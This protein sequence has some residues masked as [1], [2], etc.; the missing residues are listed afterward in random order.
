[1]KKITL[2]ICLITISL[3]AQVV[4]IPDTNFK[5]KLLQ[6]SVDNEIAK[7]L[8]GDY[9]KIDVNN[10][11]EI[12]ESEAL[13][14]SYL[15]LYNS[16]IVDMTGVEAFT[17]LLHLDCYIN[18]I[19]ILNVTTLVN[20]EYLRSS[21]NPLN[22][23]LDVS[24]NTELTFLSC[25]GNS[26]SS[27][28][29]SQN[30]NLEH[31]EC[32]NNQITSLDVSQNPNLT[33]LASGNNPLGSIDVTQNLNLVSLYCHQ[34]QLTELDI[35]QNGNLE[36]LW[37]YENQLSSIDVTSN[38]D[39]LN[40]RCYGNQ[41]T[42]LDVS[43][44]PNLESI[45]C[46]DNQLSGLDITNNINLEELRCANNQITDLDI[47][48]NT[49]LNYLRCENN[50][51]TTL[52][53]TNNGNIQ[54][55]FCN[56]NQ[57]TSL[58]IKNGNIEEGVGLHSN[59]DLQYVC[60]DE[61]E[62]NQIQASVPNV[63]VNTYCSF[64]PEGDFNTITGN[65]TFDGNNDGCDTQ[66]ALQSNI[67]VD[68]NDGTNQGAV[69]TNA[70]G[71]YTFFT[72]A[73]NFSITPNWESTNL[74]NFSPSTVVIPFSDDSNNIVTQD[75]CITANGIHNDVEVLVVP[76]ET[77]QPGFDAVYQIVYKN[78][79]NQM[80]SGTVNLMYNDAVLDYVSASIPPDNQLEDNLLWNYS[81]LLPFESRVIDVTLNVNSPMETPAVNNGDI[82]DFNVSVSPVSGDETPLDNNFDYEQ[83]V[84]GS[85]DPND[86]TCLEGDLVNPE[87]IGEYLHYNINF[88]N[89]GTAAATF[90]VVKDNID[91]SQFDINSL[92]V[93]YTSHEV[94]TRIIDNT[95]EFI[96][97]DI[98]LASEGKGNI[99]F[100]I[101]TNDDLVIGDYVENK[102][103]IF[104][105]YNF[106][107]ETNVATTVFDVL[108]IAEYDEPRINIFP[109]PSSDIVY[110]RCK[111]IIESIAVYDVHGRLIKSQQ[112]NKAE[113][114]VQ[115]SECNSGI[116][117]LKVKTENG[118]G[119]KKIVKN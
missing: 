88:E 30:I 86:I 57:L 116:Y 1:M 52:D 16:D 105:D 99:V 73:G 43:Q 21:F 20:L 26:L 54:F 38:S 32:T 24:Q 42:T 75:F 66:D 80:L 82:L 103:E 104:F 39:L 5:A 23:G 115:V 107:I 53:A 112:A 71:N 29:I 90:I 114:I 27:L 63:L 41:I 118:E 110:V 119:L 55:L 37:A 34:N 81:N 14:T 10:D 13:S 60:V 89:T 69:F 109:N 101:K 17:N 87:H 40:L 113:E 3:N 9:F 48:Q 91:N 92:Q 47:S 84:V 79:G 45:Q 4:D 49:L 83:T 106:P 61:G 44:N 28:D 56:N 7:D 51:L 98:N 25:F 65:L 111:S 11:G 62:I 72:E 94:M 85:Y 77:A 15:D 76:I 58:L 33:F 12:Q 64:T 96:F 93:L 19:E 22:D 36:L 59:P 18:D 78:K 50:L 70:S 35:T 31:L 68:I 108:S 2:I 100:K 8:N 97:D 46:Y 95:I 6:A 67:R 74:F 102:A 117:F